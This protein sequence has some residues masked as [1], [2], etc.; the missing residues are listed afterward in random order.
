VKEREATGYH[1]GAPIYLIKKVK[2]RCTWVVYTVRVHVAKL[3][4]VCE[5][6]GYLPGWSFLFLCS[7]VVK[8]KIITRQILLIMESLDMRRWWG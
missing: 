7:H 3:T 5:M 4:I 8:S 1:V 2:I 6:L